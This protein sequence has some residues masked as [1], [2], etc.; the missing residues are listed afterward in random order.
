MRR[1]GEGEEESTEN[2]AGSLRRKWGRGGG[3]G[4][5]TP[6]V[7]ASQP[8][9]PTHPPTHP[10]TPTPYTP[11]LHDELRERATYF[12]V[13]FVAL[14]GVELRRVEACLHQGSNH[15]LHGEFLLHFVELVPFVADLE[16]EDPVVG[17]AVPF[18]VI[19][20]ET[21]A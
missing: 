18:C 20:G 17:V 15:P 13:H 21:T 16:D 12:A 10:P 7:F 1:Q 4:A 9:L 6:S 8:S 3:G 11:T 5:Q 2:G 19:R 14:D